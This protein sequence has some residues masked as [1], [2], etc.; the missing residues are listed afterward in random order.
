LGWFCTLFYIDF[1]SKLLLMS[2][3]NCLFVMSWIQFWGN[4]NVREA[5]R[6]KLRI[7][8]YRII[9]GS[10]KGVYCDEFE[11]IESVNNLPEKPAAYDWQFLGYAYK[12]YLGDIESDG[13]NIINIINQPITTTDKYINYELGVETQNAAYWDRLYFDTKID[14]KWRILALYY[15]DY[16]NRSNYTVEY[17]AFGWP[18]ST[19]AAVTLDKVSLH[20]IWEPAGPFPGEHRLWGDLVLE[21]GSKVLA[22]GEFEIIDAAHAAHAG[23]SEWA[24]VS[25]RSAISAGLVPP[26]LQGDYQQPITRA[27]FCALAV[28]LYEKHTEAEITERKTFSDT[29]DV[30]VE[31]IAALGVA[32]GMGNN[33]FAPEDI[34]TREQAAVMLARLAWALGKPLTKQAA[35]FADNANIAPWAA[36]GTGRVQAAGIMG[37][38]GSN[39]FAPREPYTREQSIVTV[40]RLWDVIL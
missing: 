1:L 31:K 2:C 13:L 20:K 22:Y 3:N 40:M 32:E 25:V 36:E 23:T 8:K 34:L 24:E 17:P 30:N 38:V 39:T 18:Q 15:S 10:Y 9:Y 5:S 19:N 16:E 27:E 33:R 11:I 35:T 21:D 14:G 29:N 37:G 7:G 28:A 6:Q 26:G 12:S 4:S